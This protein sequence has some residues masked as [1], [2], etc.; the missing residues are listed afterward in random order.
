VGS[1]GAGGSVK[2]YVFVVDD[3]HGCLGDLRSD[4]SV[5]GRSFC[6]T[7]PL[8][9][10]IVQSITNKYF[11]FGPQGSGW[12]LVCPRRCFLEAGDVKSPILVVR[13]NFVR[14]P[15]KREAASAVA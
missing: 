2:S 9:P 14:N 8:P 4:L 7:L 10:K 1:H 15:L 6:L 3:D 13:A 12:G 5:L 11:R